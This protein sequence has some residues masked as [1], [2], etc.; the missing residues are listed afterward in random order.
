MK[1]VLQEMLDINPEDVILTASFRD[2]L[3]VDSLDLFEMIL[4]L[5]DEYNFRI[6]AE[7][8]QNMK[9]VGDAVKYF[10]DH[11]IHV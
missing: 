2:D 1:E 3:G 9:T 5:E 4:K 11:D 6:P 8:L 10:E 7:D